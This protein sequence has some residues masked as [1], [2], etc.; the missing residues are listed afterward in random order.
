M[1][2]ADFSKYTILD[3]VLNTNS[4]SLAK[5]GVS[6]KCFRGNFLQFSSAIA[7]IFISGGQLGTSL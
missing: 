2:A 3:K 5:I 6:V 4:P 7:K 1:N